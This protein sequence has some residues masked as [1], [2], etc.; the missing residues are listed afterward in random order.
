MNIYIKAY[1]SQKP[2]KQTVQ[3]LLEH[4]YDDADENMKNKIAAAYSYFMPAKPKKPKTVFEWL[5]LAM[6]SDQTR[7]YLKFIWCDGK[8]NAVATDGRILLKAPCDKPEGFYDHRENK[9]DHDQTFPQ[10]ERFF[11]DQEGQ[12][13]IVNLIIMSEKS[14]KTEKTD[15]LGFEIKYIDKALSLDGDK[16]IKWSCDCS[17]LQIDFED[18][19]QALIM[20]IRNPR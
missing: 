2:K 5:G 6:S 14:Y 12:E 10:W 3:E 8:G 4:L 18:G 7:P 13:E 19:R 9:I 16:K 1:N 20:P 11:P 15:D 17:P